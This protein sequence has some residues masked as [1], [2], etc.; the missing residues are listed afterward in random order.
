M[1][2]IIGSRS[3]KLNQP[4]S[5]FCVSSFP[6]WRHFVF[7]LFL[8]LIVKFRPFLTMKPNQKKKKNG[9]NFFFKI[10]SFR[11]RIDEMTTD[12]ND[13]KLLTK[14][15]KKRKI[16]LAQSNCIIG[17]PKFH[18]FFL[19]QVVRR[20]ERNVKRKWMNV[21][22]KTATGSNEGIGQMTAINCYKSVDK[23]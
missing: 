8:S 7:S 10:S 2:L 6:Y 1:S 23:R 22:N 9:N 5:I 11:K 20:E 21:E 18:F 4:T 17:S 12:T 15:K 19:R 13:W 16:K 3:A 14:K